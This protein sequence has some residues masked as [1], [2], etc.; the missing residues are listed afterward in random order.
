MMYQNSQVSSQYFDCQITTTTAYNDQRSISLGIFHDCDF[1]RAADKLLLILGYLLFEKSWKKNASIES[2]NN[3][4]N[5]NQLYDVPHYVLIH[6]KTTT[7][8]Q[9]IIKLDETH[10]TRKKITYLAI[11]TLIILLLLLCFCFFN[12]K[13]KASSTQ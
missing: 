9:Q 2:V 8:V 3:R 6:H 12:N 13:L 10:W 4:E 5:Y 7:S 11:A 1:Y